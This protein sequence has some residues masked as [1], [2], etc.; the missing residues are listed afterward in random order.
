MN[1]ATF[2][3]PAPESRR[4]V[5]RQVTGQRL[6]RNSRGPAVVVRRRD[7]RDVE[8]APLESL[9]PLREPETDRAPKVL[10]CQ[11]RRRATNRRFFIR[12]R[13]AKY[14]RRLSAPIRPLGS[15]AGVD[16]VLE[17][18]AAQAQDR[19]SQRFQCRT[20]E[21]IPVRVSTSCNCLTMAAFTSGWACPRQNTAGP[22]EPSR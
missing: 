12:P 4:R 7:E 16:D 21:Q 18:A 15:A 9:A 3:G 20:R 10:P 6:R 8:Q 11:D 19:F 22:P 5:R 17:F 14:W 2:C 1:A 13:A